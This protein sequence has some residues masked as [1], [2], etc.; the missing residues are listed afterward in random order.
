[1]KGLLTI[2]L[3]LSFFNLNF[4]CHEH[5]HHHGM[6]KY[7]LNHELVLFIVICTFFLSI[8]SSKGLA[9]QSESVLSFEGESAREAQIEKI[10][11]VLDRP[12]AQ[13]HLI[14]MGISKSQLRE[15]LSQLDDTQ[16]ALV[17]ERADAVKA[18]GDEVVGAV[19]IILLI[20]FLVILIF[21][22]AH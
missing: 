8:Q 6:R 17:S 22:F 13:L 18:A 15:Q 1:M 9:L 10:M 4:G 5:H 16:L 21:H 11:S 12:E 7:L 20:V 14:A 19:L 3:S 2:L